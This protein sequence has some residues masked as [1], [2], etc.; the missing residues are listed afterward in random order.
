MLLFRSILLTF[1]EYADY[2]Y[3]ACTFLVSTSF[4]ASRNSSISH[5]TK[6]MLAQ[7]IVV[8]YSGGRSG[9]GL[10]CL[11]VYVRWE[12][13]G[14]RKRFTSSQGHSITLFLLPPPHSKKSLQKS[15]FFMGGGN[16]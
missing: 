3:S 15:Y 6:L 2:A 4:P 13:E 10:S 16:V 12:K 14:E 11:S 7:Y 9:I 1:A 8:V 5:A